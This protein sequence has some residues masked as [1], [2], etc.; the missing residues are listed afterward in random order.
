[1]KKLVRN[2]KLIATV[3]TNGKNFKRGNEMKNIGILEACSIFIE[4][5]LI[6]DFIPNSKI[7]E[8][9]Y[10]EI[11]DATDSIVAP[12]FVECHTHLVYSGSRANEFKE[13]IAGKSYEEIAAQ[14]GG[15][16]ATVNAVRSATYSDLVESSLPRINYFISQGVA[17]IEIKSG[18]GLNFEDEIKCLNAINY[19]KQNLQIDIIPTFLGAHTVPK[20]YQ[21]KRNEYI[22]IIIEQ[23]LP[24]IA[25]NKLSGFCDGFCETTAFSAN[26]IDLIFNHAY[27]L[28]FKLRLHT[29]QFNNIGGLETALKHNVISIDHLEKIKDGD[30]MK[31]AQS[32]SVLTLL[33]G[34]SFFL[35]YEYAPARKLIDAGGIVAL[36][37]DF[38][39]GSSHIFNISLI[40]S[41]AS[42]KMKMTI[43]EIISAF[44]INAAHAIGLSDKIGSVE[45]GKRADFAIFE[46]EDLSDLIYCVGRNLNTTT[47]KNGEIIYKV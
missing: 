41:L 35:D 42:I 25:K 5:G 28:G 29:E 14:G 47:V 22:Q 20:E 24:F 45:P 37:T 39:P 18:Y 4:N 43:E 17:A 13:K 30:I 40:M 32:N 11:I 9:N 7:V 8:S 34:V 16:M 21:S 15:I 44:T 38:N 27:K 26:E 33:P 6:K 3:S 31:T 36:S 19:L 23:L 2:P 1:M 10:D 12:G 46:A